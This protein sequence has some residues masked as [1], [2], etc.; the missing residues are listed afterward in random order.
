MTP[1]KTLNSV[2][3]HAST[4]STSSLQVSVIN[5]STFP[6]SFVDLLVKCRNQDAVVSMSKTCVLIIIY[7][8]GIMQFQLGM[9]FGVRFKVRTFGNKHPD[10]SNVRIFFFIFVSDHSIYIQMYVNRVFL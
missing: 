3:N 6:K 4:T 5:S 1:K 7:N 8:T 2:Q 10:G 9:S